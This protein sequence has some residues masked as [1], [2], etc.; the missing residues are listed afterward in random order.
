MYT[1]AKEFLLSSYESL[2]PPADRPLVTLTYAQSLDCKIAIKGQQLLLSGKE[3]MAMTHR[4]RVLNDAILVGSGTAN[5][6]DPQLNARHLPPDEIVQ[7]PQPIVLDARL[8][9]PL[10]CKLIKNYQANT[11]KQPWI[12]T[13]AK[14]DAQ[15]KKAL[16]Q[17]GAQ[18]LCLEEDQHGRLAW[19]DVLQ[20]LHQR[21]ICRLMV[22]GGSRIIQSCLT[23][24]FVDALVVTVCPVYI[25]E[26]GLGI[27]AE[28]GVHVVK[29]E[30]FGQDMVLFGSLKQ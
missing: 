26:R 25:G 2:D 4:L 1:R 17:A 29:Y 20:V 7:Q 30:K 9:T 16:E 27:V 10:A 14:A 15:K 12:L 3:S 18:V 22:E 28:T 5:I 19:S 23:S 8:E 24:G 21:K 6:D 11:G 13:S